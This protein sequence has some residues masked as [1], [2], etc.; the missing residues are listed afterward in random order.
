MIGKKIKG[1]I[2]IL[3]ISEYWIECNIRG[4]KE[5]GTKIVVETSIGKSKLR[6]VIESN[7][8]L[9]KLISLEILIS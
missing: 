1:N 9:L 4:S 8:E 6:L 5:K 2:Y 7:I 3:C